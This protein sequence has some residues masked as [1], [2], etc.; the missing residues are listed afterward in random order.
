VLSKDT[1]ITLTM[2]RGRALEL[3]LL[4]CSCGHPE[5]NHFDFNGH[6]CAHCDCKSYSER[7]RRGTTLEVLR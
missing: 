1:R 5:N 2:T 7:G 6:P 3:G 4:T